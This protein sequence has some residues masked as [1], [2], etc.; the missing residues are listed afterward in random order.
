MNTYSIL[1]L[2]TGLCYLI[3]GGFLYFK[4]PKKINHI[5]G[6]RTG[7]AMKSQKAWDLAQKY[8]SIQMLWQGSIFLLLGMLAFLLPTSEAAWT[9]ALEIMLPIAS[10][11]FGVVYMIYKTDRYLERNLD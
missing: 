7:K 8:S 3:A 11:L 1:F 4:P 10:I 9:E 2:S 6:F 5:Y